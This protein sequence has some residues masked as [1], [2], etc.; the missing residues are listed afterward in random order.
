MR[1]ELLV[2]EGR[3]SDGA[4]R[5]AALQLIAARV[6]LRPAGRYGSL[7]RQRL[8]TAGLI[9]A[10]WAVLAIGI[11]AR[12][13]VE[14]NGPITPITSGSAASARMLLAPFS[15]SCLP[16]TASSFAATWT[17]NPSM[18][19]CLLTKNCTPLSAGVPARPSGPDSGRS[20][21]SFNGLNGGR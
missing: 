21:P 16:A 11:S 3:R 13:T 5:P 6:G 19:G 7:V 1:K 18:V 8:L 9:R 10:R 4:A 2:P 20:T 15:G 12:A 17:V 14:S